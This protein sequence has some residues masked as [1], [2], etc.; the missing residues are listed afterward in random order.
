MQCGQR[1]SASNRPPP[2]ARRWPCVR[3]LEVLGSAPLRCVK[4]CRACDICMRH[5]SKSYT[6]AI[7]KPL[8]C[9]AAAGLAHHEAPQTRCRRPQGCAR[10]RP[11]GRGS[12][13][14]L[15]QWPSAACTPGPAPALRMS[16]LVSTC[17]GN[18]CSASLCGSARARAPLCTHKAAV[19]ECHRADVVVCAV[20]GVIGAGVGR[21]GR[22]AAEHGA[23]VAQPRDQQRMAPQQPPDGGRAVRQRRGARRAA[24][25]A[26]RRQRGRVSLRHRAAQRHLDVAAADVRPPAGRSASCAD[27]LARLVTLWRAVVQRG[28][29]AVAAGGLLG[30]GGCARDLGDT[31]TFT[32]VM[33]IMHE[34]GGQ[35]G[36]EAS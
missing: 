13:R 19:R 33:C 26:R 25:A 30:E 1:P 14:Q 28:G 18:T 36:V 35:P 21:A 7:W 31:F 5:T 12:G 10:A 3:H 11:R 17:V 32:H 24:R 2:Q 29:P 27:R 23:R 9:A 34:Q 16:T 4:R 20:V 8:A 22:P 6:P 15:A